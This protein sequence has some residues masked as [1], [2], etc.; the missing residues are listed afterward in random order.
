[1]NGP[2]F[3]TWGYVAGDPTTS[4]LMRKEKE[5]EKQKNKPDRA[6]MRPDCVLRAEYVYRGE[7]GQTD[8]LTEMRP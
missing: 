3:I 4:C 2:P 5:K 7:D 1:M 8:P 6:T